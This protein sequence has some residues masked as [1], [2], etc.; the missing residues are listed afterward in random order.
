MFAWIRSLKLV[1]PRVFATCTRPC[2]FVT[3]AFHA[4]D[5]LF[6]HDSVVGLSYAYVDVCV[7]CVL[8]GSIRPYQ[9][10]CTRNH[11]NSEVKRAWACLVL[12]WGTTREQQ[13]LYAT[14]YFSQTKHNCNNVNHAHTNTNSTNT[15]TTATTWSITTTTTPTTCTLALKLK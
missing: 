9:Y 8:S 6:L 15:N 10:E 2:L 4:Y 3:C 7:F 5:H 14:H 13:V 12:G 1:P 11:Q